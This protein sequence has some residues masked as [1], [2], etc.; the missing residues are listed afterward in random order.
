MVDRLWHLIRR[1]PLVHFLV[2]AALL[3]AADRLV[4]SSDRSTIVI[5]RQSIAA[6]LQ[7]RA[8]ALG[9]P[10]SEAERDAAIQEYVD[11]E[12][13]LHEAYQRGLDR[14]RVI[15]S[16]LVQ[17]MRFLLTDDLPEPDEADLRA[18]FEANRDRYRSPPTVTVDHVYYANLERVPEDLLEQLRDGV[19]FRQLG[20]PLFMLG[21]TLPRYS[22]RDLIGVMG[23]DVARRIFELPPGEWV[24]PL[25]SDNGVH[26]VRVVEKH[27]AAVPAF[28]EIE[29]YLR[30]DW[31]FEQQKR[32]LADK[33]AELR[34]RYRIV[35]EE[36]EDER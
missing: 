33:A 23:P 2:L 13:L 21:P 29:S 30:Q 15:R 16:R 24:G 7:A 32:V 19:D 9:R 5:D 20:E 10:L 28:E 4:G 26:F 34:Q 27:A 11:E 14:D 12:V 17:K 18:Y 35:I 31:L 1:E 8:E 6:A 36:P 25:H 22:L 3:F